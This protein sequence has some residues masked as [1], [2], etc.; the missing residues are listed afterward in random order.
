MKMIGWLV[1]L[2]IAVAIAV[3]AFVLVN[4]GQVVKTAIED[5]GPQYLGA[6]VRVDAVELSLTEGQGRIDGLRIGNPAGFE[7]ADALAMDKIAVDIDTSK[8]SA[9]LVVIKS[10]LIDGAQ[11][12][13]LAKGQQTNFQKLV[14]NLERALGPETSPTPRFKVERLAFTNAQ[15][16]LTSDILGAT[17]LDIPDINLRRVG[18]PNGVSGA[19]L[20]EAL[21]QPLT[22]SVTREVVNQGLDID[23]VKN[24]VETRIRGA[25]GDKLSDL[26]KRD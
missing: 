17:R 7:G 2:V 14:E 20:G 22:R 5:Y 19:E 23:G 24:K 6:N 11:I 4:S 1:G 3:V 8:T 25:I 9:D 12:T 26:L 21:L 15:A 13:A 16:S 18:Y 10:I